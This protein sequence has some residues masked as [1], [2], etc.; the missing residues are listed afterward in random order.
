V[1]ELRIFSRDEEKQLD[2]QRE[3][4]DPRLVY[5]IGDVR[6]RKRVLEATRGVDA[7]YHAA[8]L[9]VIPSCEDNVVET[10]NTN[11][12]G[13]INVRN[14][15][16]E[17]DVDTAVLVSTDK[18]V[19]PVN[20]YGMTKAI[21]EKIWLEWAHKQADHSTVNYSVVRYGNVVGSRGSIVPFFRQLY[22]KKKPIPI[23]DPRMTR[24]MITLKQAINLVFYAT[25]KNGLTFVPKIPAANVLDIAT[26][27]CG[28]SYPTKIVGIRPG[29]K[30][31]ECLINE[32]EIMQT[33]YEPPYY[34]IG[35]T[36]KERVLDEEY[37]SGMERKMSVQEIKELL[38]E[39]PE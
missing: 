23:T 5:L 22:A 37:T 17:N 30:I 8:A 21:A 6:D 4:Q 20:L 36:P 12:K 15:A 18:A 10:I 32:Y 19:K 33:G 31:H 16:H 1:R 27:I 13:T 7:I 38:K 14:A 29:E 9:K 2:M 11:V 28:P 34:V 24:F 26:A 35:K 39:V 3:I 25:G